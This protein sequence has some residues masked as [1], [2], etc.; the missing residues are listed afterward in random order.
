MASKPETTYL[1]AVGRKLPAVVYREKMANP[2]RRG[3]PDMYYEGS[4]DS[5]FIEY[6]WFP[7]LPK[8]FDLRDQKKG[9]S[10]SK[11]QQDWLHR[12]HGNQRTVAVVVGTPD[13]GILLPGIAWDGVITPT[14]SML[15][16]KEEIAQWIYQ[17]TMLPTSSTSN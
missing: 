9:T 17:R 7:K 12:A 2:Y 13:G 3:T 5:L 16:T 1:E 8:A 10:L 14:Q 11:H 4:A 15:R 6:K